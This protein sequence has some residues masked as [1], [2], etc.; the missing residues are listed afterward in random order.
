LV[1]QYEVR[2]V[3]T[4]DDIAHVS[5][6][7]A[8]GD[9][10]E[11]G[12][13]LRDL[14]LL[15]RYSRRANEALLRQ[16]SRSIE[17]SAVGQPAG[18]TG[19]NGAPLPDGDLFLV[20]ADEIAVEEEWAL[21]RYDGGGL[22]V[23]LALANA[24]IPADENVVTFDLAR[25]GAVLEALLRISSMPPA[26]RMIVS[27]FVA[28]YGPRA[29]GTRPH[30][31]L[32]DANRDAAELAGDAP[33]YGQAAAVAG[34][35]S[36]ALTAA[37]L[38]ASAASP[39]PQSTS[40]ILV[41]GIL[42]AVAA[43]CW[44]VLDGKATSEHARRSVG[45]LPR[46][47]HAY[48]VMALSAILAV[49][50][51]ELVAG[52]DPS[53]PISPGVHE[54]LI[55]AAAGGGP[56]LVQLFVTRRWSLGWLVALAGWMA[57]LDARLRSSTASVGTVAAVGVVAV[58]SPVV[59]HQLPSSAAGNQL[60]GQW[61]VDRYAIVNDQG[62][63]KTTEWTAEKWTVSKATCR[64]GTCVVN[65]DPETGQ[66]FVLTSREGS[67][68]WSGTRTQTSE[69]ARETSTGAAVTI[70][71]KGYENREE[72]SL[73]TA[74]KGAATWFTIRDHVKAVATSEG[75]PRG[76]GSPIYA[77]VTSTASRLHSRE[78]HR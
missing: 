9:A 27:D 68:T 33:R 39:G 15:A 53:A 28:V 74:Q 24:T 11:T 6:F 5:L 1:G 37:M 78:A 72:L 63:I 40:W 13:L 25:Y 75:G 16:A 58:V 45:D 7:R 29:L 57:G 60:A 31:D 36:I 43:C 32:V 77:L 42:A 64:R 51:V 55:L 22:R 8:P 62:W 30:V 49:V 14:V 70:A 56:I 19:A 21:L 44:L 50:G 35:S 59:I 66:H 65:V 2:S 18:Q 4:T 61:Y 52:F 47:P 41:G 76:C 20:F 48:L 12:L 67:H 17:A 10:A 23:V 46:K 71:S 34:F 3:T 38:G 73:A 26:E 69:C 54:L